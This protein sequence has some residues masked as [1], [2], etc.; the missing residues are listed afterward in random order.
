MSSDKEG[1]QDY[2]WLLVSTQIAGSDFLSLGHVTNESV[3]SI[4]KNDT[5]QCKI[6]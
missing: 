3:G 5:I 6:S 4:Y 2:G 1:A